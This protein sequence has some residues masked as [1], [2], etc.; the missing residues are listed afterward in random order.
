MVEW[1]KARWQWLAGLVGSVVLLA[2]VYLSGRSLRKGDIEI[3]LAKRELEK[4]NT[5]YAESA[6]TTAALH[7][8]QKRLVSDILSEQLLRAEQLKRSKGLTDAQVLDDL[9]RRGDINE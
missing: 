9:R 1:F 5:A 8:K 4:A 2:A 6:K 3:G 7:E